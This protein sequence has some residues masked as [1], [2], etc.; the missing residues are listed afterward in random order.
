MPLFCN[1]MLPNVLYDGRGMVA[2]NGV[3]EL[4]KGRHGVLHRGRALLFILVRG[5]DY[6]PCKPSPR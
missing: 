5:W 2:D 1:I 3:G 4:F 6:T